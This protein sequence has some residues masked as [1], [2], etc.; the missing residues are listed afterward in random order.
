MALR[1]VAD[2]APRHIRLL[3]VCRSCGATL[4]MQA[5][6]SHLEL[7]RDQG[8]TV[9]PSRMVLMGA[10]DVGLWQY[11]LTLEVRAVPPAGED[12]TAELTQIQVDRAGAQTDVKG[13]PSCH[14]SGRTPDAAV[15][16]AMKKFDDWLREQRLDRR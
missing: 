6:L 10:R 5:P 1:D 13:A 8:R 4:R 3:Y 12:Y 9:G 2:T 11:L 16:A 15:D 7:V 14:S